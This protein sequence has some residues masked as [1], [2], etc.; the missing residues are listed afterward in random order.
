[1]IRVETSVV[2]KYCAAV[3]R[4]LKIRCFNQVE[5][6]KLLKVQSI[7]D[8]K[9]YR[10]LVI[11]ACVVDYNDDILPSIQQR[12]TDIGQRHSLE[13][14]VY[15]A[16][17]EINPDLE[18]TK[19]VLPIQDREE[20][21]SELH[22]FDSDPEIEALRSGLNIDG[23]ADALQKDIIGQDHAVDRVCH[24]LKRAAAGLT[25]PN[26]PMGSF[27]FIG[28]TGVGKTEMAKSLTRHALPGLDHLVRVDCSEYAQGHEY[29]KLIGAPPGYIGHNEGGYLT[30]K[31][32]R[33]RQ[34]VILFDEVEKADVKLHNLLLQLLDEGFITDGK[35]TRVP[36]NQVLLIM[37]SNIGLREVESL[38]SRVGF[39][40]DEEGP[41]CEASREQIMAAL[42]RRFP[43]EFINRIDEIVFFKVLGLSES[44]RIVRIQLGRVQERARE[45]GI[46]L[47]F[48]PPLERHLAECGF[49][50]TYGARNLRREIRRKVE[51]PLAERIL[52]KRIGSGDRI[53][54]GLRRSQVYF[55]RVN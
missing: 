7:R 38:R 2:L 24:A 33:L 43:P 44:V 26:R 14:D 30:E 37:T 45:R 10:Q 8:S 34:A 49:D 16:C 21:H 13:K 29:A 23:L 1:M 4:F 19:V 39:R 35:G 6:T 52:D 31:M 11:N 36:C 41:S 50:Q 40:E 46:Q 5:I 12:V 22:L 54:V 48:T 18:I 9:E 47:S 17:V 20:S 3:D 15:E 55:H 32:K 42:R 25:S 27:F 53:R 51:G 28:Q